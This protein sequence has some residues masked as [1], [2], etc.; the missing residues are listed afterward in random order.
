MRFAHAV[1][2]RSYA[3]CVGFRYDHLDEQDVRAKMLRA[4]S[5]EWT[6]LSANFP[7]G[8]CYGKQL[9][10]AGWVAFE[11]AMPEALDS[12]DD[13]WL[14]DA[15][16]PADY[17]QDRSPRRTKNGIT[18]VNYNKRDA[19][20]RLCFGEFN[21]AYIRGLALALLARGDTT[22]IVY[23]ADAAYVPRGECTDWEGQL[24]PLA[25]VVSGHRARYHPPPGDRRAWSIP[26]G[27]NC[28]HSI[29]AA[30]PR[31]G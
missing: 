21:I 26:S 12:R 29:R 9:T 14:V 28:H 16:S 15:M 11:R 3:L 4:W 18:M 1:P 22:C 25:D 10:D 8:Q 23:R 24:F 6:E 19:L 30:T 31:A 2:C 27:P 7:R 5:E 17:W 20:E 13:D